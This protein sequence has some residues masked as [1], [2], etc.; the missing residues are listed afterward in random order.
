MALGGL[1]VAALLSFLI[2]I[3]FKS[4]TYLLFGLSILG[5]MLTE[6]F[7]T[8]LL[9]RYFWPA[10]WPM[11]TELSTVFALWTLATFVLFF[12]SI[13]PKL[14]QYRWQHHAF[15]GMIGLTLLGQMWALLIHYSA[16]TKFWTITL[17]VS[18]FMGLI[19]VV[20]VW[21][22]GGR[23]AGYLLLSFVMIGL[24]EAMRLGVNLGILP[25]YQGEM[26]AGPWALMLAT[27]LILL[28][29]FER[30]QELENRLIKIEAENSAKLNFLSRMSHELRT[31]LN[32]ILGYTELLE[33]HSPRV[34]I[35]EAT[36]AIKQSGKYLLGMIDEILDHTR[37][38]T[39]KIKLE[40]APVDLMAF[41]KEIERNTTLMCQPRGNYFT[42]QTV[43]K[44]PEATRRITGAF[45]A[46]D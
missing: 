20:S 9:Q 29:I 27:P 28:S 7:R 22:D 23:K 43:G 45:A 17:N 4:L 11:I 31:P 33:R 32:A 8:G 10:E 2:Y 12:R 21:R 19:L 44:I 46:H 13:F 38:I 39:G 40:P 6:L 14:E 34:S 16:G 41:L 36:H 24:V 35:D 25:F 42:L 3:A 18:L 26:L 1:I 15:F 37:S 30:S 5:A